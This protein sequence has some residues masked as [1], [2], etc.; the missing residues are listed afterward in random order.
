MFSERPGEHVAGTPPLSLGVGHLGESLE[1]GGSGRK[2][3]WD[4]F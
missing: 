1:D 2:E 3:S 4:L